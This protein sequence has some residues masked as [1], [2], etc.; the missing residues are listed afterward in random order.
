[1]SSGHFLLSAE[2]G[3]EFLPLFSS[4]Q[5]GFDLSKGL[6]GSR[7]GVDPVSDPY[8]YADQDVFNAVLCARF[9]DRVVRLD[10]S[11]WSY[12]PFEGLTR[13]GGEGLGCA[14]ADGSQP[15]LLHHFFH[16]PWL[17]PVAP[18]VYSELF[19]ELVTDPAA[20]IRLGKGDIPLRLRDSGLAPLDRWR[21]SV[22]RSARARFRGRLGLRPVLE[23][24][25]RRANERLRSGR[26]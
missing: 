24:E 1:V 22:Q 15:Y 16:K 23:R 5:E 2:T 20:P 19:T 21:A 18:N 8:F 6:F 11:S 4:L 13:S 7:E 10:M 25:M 17:S 3:A 9:D 12:P 26:R 14:Y